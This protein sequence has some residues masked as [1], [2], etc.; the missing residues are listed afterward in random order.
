MECRTLGRHRVE[1]MEV[2]KDE[3]PVGNTQSTTN[4][5]DACHISYFSTLS[6]HTRHVAVS[7]SDGLFHLAASEDLLKCA[8]TTYNPSN[9]VTSLCTPRRNFVKVWCSRLKAFKGMPVWG[10]TS[11]C[12]KRELVHF[13]VTKGWHTLL[14][15]LPHVL[16][17][18]IL[19]TEGH[20][21]FCLASKLP[22]EQWTT[23]ES[24]LQPNSSWEKTWTIRDSMLTVTSTT[25]SLCNTTDQWQ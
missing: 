15:P 14:R 4:F 1:V 20:F 25:W 23:A 7:A 6:I 5:L 2:N 12:V 8:Q 24:S 11:V 13:L 9:T 18:I 22:N 21:I 19:S 10:D 17:L 3:I 16:T